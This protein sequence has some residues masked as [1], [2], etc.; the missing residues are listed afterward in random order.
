MD[1][2]S[3]DRRDATEVARGVESSLRASLGEVAG[4]YAAESEGGEANISLCTT[5]FDYEGGLSVTTCSVISGTD[6]SGNDLSS[7]ESAFLEEFEDFDEFGDSDDALHL[8]HDHVT[9]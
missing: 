6:V 1:E 7:L 4:R 5:D 3:Q 2:A 9:Q 8:D